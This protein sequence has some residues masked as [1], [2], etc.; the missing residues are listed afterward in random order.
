MTV[1][2]VCLASVGIAF[3]LGAGIAL[4]RADDPEPD[5]PP[6]RPDRGDGIPAPAV[7]PA[8]PNADDVEIAP[9]VDRRELWKD[10]LDPPE[11]GFVP[12]ST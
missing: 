10:V 4:V 2:L 6:A 11:P 1:T 9:F 3:F 12:K 5:S 7:T 8:K